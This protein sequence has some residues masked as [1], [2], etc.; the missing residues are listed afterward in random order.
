[1]KRVL[2]VSAGEN[3]TLAIVKGGELYVWG[4][5]RYGQLGLQHKRNEGEEGESMRCT[6]KRVDF[7]AHRMNVTAIAAGTRHSIVMTAGEEIYGFGSNTVGQLGIRDGFQ[8]DETITV[9]QRVSLPVKSTQVCESTHMVVA[10]AASHSHTCILI[11][12]QVWQF[13]H[14]SYRPFLLSFRQKSS[15]VQPKEPHHVK[16]HIW[17]PWMKK[18]HVSMTD[19]ACG[20]NH[21][22]AMDAFGRAYIWKHP[23][24]S[25]SSGSGSGAHCPEE[26]QVQKFSTRPTLVR[27]LAPQGRVISISTAAKKCAVVTDVGDVFQC[28]SWEC[29]LS[30]DRPEYS[31]KKVRQLKNVRQVSLGAHHTAVRVQHYA[32]CLPN[33][34]ADDDEENGQGKVMKEDMDFDDEE[35]DGESVDEISHGPSKS[36]PSLWNL[37]QSCLCSVVDVHN[38]VTL[39][40]YAE[41]FQAPVLLEYCSEF[42]RRNLDAVL[43]M[44]R[45]KKEMELF[46]DMPMIIPTLGDHR[47]EDE[48]EL[49]IE[50]KSTHPLKWTD[51]FYLCKTIRSLRKRLRQVQRLER[52]QQEQGLVEDSLKYN[53]SEE[54][55]RK[56]EL[57]SEWN[58][59]L[60]Q[61]YEYLIQHKAEY[62]ASPR[63]A[64]GKI[65]PEHEHIFDHYLRQYAPTHLEENEVMGE[66]TSRLAAPAVSVS[67]AAMDNHVDH[68]DPAR[69]TTSL[70][71]ILGQ[72]S[73]PSKS[74]KKMKKKKH[75]IFK[76]FHLNEENSRHVANNENTNQNSG[77]SVMPHWYP[78]SVMPVQSIIIRDIMKDEQLAQ[79]HGQSTR[80]TTKV[81]KKTSAKPRRRVSLT[82]FLNEAEK[83]ISST[84]VPT[85]QSP[86]LSRPTHSPSLLDI[87]VRLFTAFVSTD[88]SNLNL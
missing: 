43:V 49:E 38:V 1:M 6:P 14:G 76:P 11:H 47:R 5:N 73:Q 23:L 25:C 36:I 44:M 55:E 32:P 51:D 79:E 71:T 68:H 29:E 54:E 82:S 70:K 85:W 28:E 3:H 61:V 65:Y 62:K 46:E 10:A 39:L 41:S 66:P 33:V 64:D 78:S 83:E 50:S 24:A 45:E 9:P 48:I 18:A 77:N 19:I 16:Q 84:S 75:L 4:S 56:L 35:K 60:C 80:V 13:G 31:W 2:S 63:L 15:K 26:R 72:G 7:F 86:S 59:E 20:P 37:A 87:Q 21:S 30:N 53:P 67:I 58:K 52:Q 57:A 17:I 8:S 88:P 42:L 69:T 27:G 34:Y 12:S 81:N 74:K 22:M 40:S